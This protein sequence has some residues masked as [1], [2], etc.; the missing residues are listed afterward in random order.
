MCAVA[1]LVESGG[2]LVLQREVRY[3]EGGQVALDKAF[4]WGMNWSR[5]RK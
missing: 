4:G 5:G 3:I 2:D 1:Q